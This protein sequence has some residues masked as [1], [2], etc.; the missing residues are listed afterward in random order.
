MSTRCN[1]ILEQPDKGRKIYLYHHFDGYP[2]GVGSDLAHFVTEWNKSYFYDICE[3]ANWLIKNPF[4]P[5][6][7]R[8]DDNYRLTKGLHGD[9]EYLYV[10]KMTYD[11]DA[12]RNTMT[13]EAYKAYPDW[14]IES[15][16]KNEIAIRKNKDKPHFSVIDGM[17]VLPI[18]LA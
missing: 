9:I 4:A 5:S 16:N 7:E 2:E 1:I 14:L 8:E 3:L 11:N 10:I 17:K 18:A 15:I 13:L 6:Y 12:K